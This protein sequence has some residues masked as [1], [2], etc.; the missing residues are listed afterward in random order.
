MNTDSCLKS[1]IFWE[2]QYLFKYCSNQIIRRCILDEKIK[3]LLSFGHEL[4]CG[5]HFGPR[6]T[7][8][9]ALQTG[10]Y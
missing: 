1:D 5:G 10:L 9:K 2:E 7:V 3:S 6:M 4:A 8:E